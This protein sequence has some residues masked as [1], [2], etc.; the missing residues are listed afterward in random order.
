MPTG[1]ISFPF[2]MQYLGSKA[3]IAGWIIDSIRNWKPDTNHLLD[4]MA[5]SGAV[6]HAAHMANMRI[7]ANDLQPYAARVLRAAFLSDRSGVLAT[8]Q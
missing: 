6:S 7:C 1:P 4:A 3:R 5:G 8:I 2:P